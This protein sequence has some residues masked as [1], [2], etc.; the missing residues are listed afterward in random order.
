MGSGVW[1]SAGPVC[2][3][4]LLF[5]GKESIYLIDLQKHFIRMQVAGYWLSDNHHARV[6]AAADARIFYCR[7][8]AKS[9]ARVGLHIDTPL[10]WIQSKGL[11]RTLLAQQLSPV[12]VL[13]A[14]IV[15]AKAVTNNSHVP[16]FVK[17]PT[18]CCTACTAH[19][20]I[21]HITVINISSTSSLINL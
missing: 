8:L 1:P 17:T 3:Q 4:R 10:C 11:Q 19:T 14:T 2:R 12:N 20:S 5:A 16:L 6:T 21:K 7:T 18:A 9:P 15:P 13:I